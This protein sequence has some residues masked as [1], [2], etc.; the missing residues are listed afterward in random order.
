MAMPF[1]TVVSSEQVSGAA[2]GGAR[3]PQAQLLVE[4]VG[5]G[6]EQT[7]QLIGEKAA[8]AGSIDLEPVVQFFDPILDVAAGP[9]SSV[10]ARP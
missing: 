3:G 2:K 6:A 9:R 8:A 10:L 7:P 5:G 1:S 4:H